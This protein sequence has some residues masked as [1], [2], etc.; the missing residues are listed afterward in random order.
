MKPGLKNGLYKVAETQL[1]PGVNQALL[2]LDDGRI[3]NLREAKN[4]LL[5]SS[6]GVDVLKTADGQL[7]YESNEIARET[8]AFHV[9]STPRGGQYSITLP[10]GSRVWLNAVSSL[11]YPV[12][13]GQNERVVELNGEGFFEIAPLLKPGTKL[14]EPS[15]G[16]PEKIPFRVKL[17]D[18]ASVMV[19]GTRFN[20][21]SYEGEAEIKTTLLEGRV[22]VECEK[23]KKGEAHL[24][25]TG[26]PLPGGQ[27]VIKPDGD[28]SIIDS[29]NT[30]EAIA[31]KN[32][33]FKFINAPIESIMRQVERWYGAEV[34]YEG[35]IDYHFNATI[36]RNEPL[37]R[38]L[39]L[40][41][42][43]RRVKFTI[44]GN[45]I[46]VIQQL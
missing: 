22:R 30:D 12:V 7:S 35:K 44:E 18:G 17:R 37:T 33:Q 2:T 6:A 43:T 16:T 29:V 1:M 3:I 39:T 24:Y 20:V 41:E 38:L 13:F 42:K 9:L 28:I 31:W 34:K 21:M 11:K 26:E 15:S 8:T 36:Y 25:R 14:N 23:L 27:A 32:G 5:D 46:T 40:L 45:R 4:G 19:M 10:D